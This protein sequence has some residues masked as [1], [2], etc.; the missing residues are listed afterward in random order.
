ML[1]LGAQVDCAAA[2]FP[3]Y[4][5]MSVLVC[6]FFTLVCVELTLTVSTLNRGHKIDFISQVK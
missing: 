6:A 1:V 5:L 4:A 2:F 3:V